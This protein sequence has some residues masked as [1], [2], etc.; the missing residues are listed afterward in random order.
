[1]VMVMGLV[2]MMVTAMGLVMMMVPMET[3]NKIH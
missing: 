1:M 2:M 3:I